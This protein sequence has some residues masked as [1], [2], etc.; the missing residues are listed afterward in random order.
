[1]SLPTS[2]SLTEIDS[3]APR[4]PVLSV[5]H[6]LFNWTSLKPPTPRHSFAWMAQ[7]I[8]MLRTSH[9]ATHAARV[10]APTPNPR[11]QARR[12][13]CRAPE[14]TWCLTMLW[15]CW[16]WYPFLRLQST[17]GRQWTSRTASA[18]AAS[19]ASAGCSPLR[20]TG[21]G[22]GCA[23]APPRGP[24]MPPAMHLGSTLPDALR[25]GAHLARPNALVTLP[26]R[27]PRLRRF[28]SRS[29]QF[30]P[31][32][33]RTRSL[34]SPPDPLAAVVSVDAVGPQEVV[35]ED[36]QLLRPLHS[37]TNTNTTTTTTTTTAAGR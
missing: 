10:H 35:P 16:Q 19:A 14:M 17:W 36:P 22:C 21:Q 2:T 31:L 26:I 24:E 1:M 8:Y 18:S 5:C 30:I 29:S 20:G 25:I 6:R 32:K 4:N 7:L 13:A 37:T 28:G 33:P 34:P 11:H 27:H 3:A 23:Q 15:P 12:H 9:L